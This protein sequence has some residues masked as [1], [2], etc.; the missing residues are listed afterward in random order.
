[1]ADDTLLLEIGKRVRERREELNLTQ[2]ILAEKM[3]V[4]NLMVSNLENGKKAIRPEN[5]VKLSNVLGISTDYILKGIRTNAEISDL[6]QRIS[7]LSERGQYMVKGV[8]ELAENEER[9]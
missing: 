8:I 5:L 7:K 9:R 4:S 2:E 3:G 6:S 1:M